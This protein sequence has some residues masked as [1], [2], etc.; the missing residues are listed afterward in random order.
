MSLAHTALVVLAVCPPSFCAAGFQVHPG[1]ISFAAALAQEPVN[2][3][4][5]YEKRRKEAE[6]D[7]KKLWSLYEWCDKN[8][9][10]TEARSCLRAILK[11][12]D[13]DKR[14]HELLGEVFYDG[15]WFPNEKKVEEYKQK[16]L[17]AKA[18]SS[19]KVIYKGEL[20]DPADVPF[21]EKGLTKTEDGRWVNAEEEKKIKE[22]WVRQDLEWIPP[23]EVPQKEKG[24]WKC[25][26]NWLAT[27]EAD[28]F[29]SEVGRWWRIPS[30]HF[31]LYSTCSRAVSEQALLKMESAYR[32]LAR[33][34]G[35]NP[36]TQVVVGL[37]NSRDQYGLFARGE[38][39]IP[40][41]E[42]RGLSSVHGSFMG[43]SWLEPVDAGFPMAGVAYWDV[44]NAKDKAFGEMFARHAAGQ[45]FAEALD[46]SPKTLAK[47]QKSQL[48]A[49]LGVEFWA[50]KKIPEWF[51]FGAA[52][53]VE[54]YM[55]DNL[56]EAGG[57]PQWRFKWSVENLTNKGGLDPLD[58][59]FEFKVSVDDIDGSNKL[60][61]ESGLLVAFV[62]DGKCPSVI[63]K[64]GALKEAIKSGKDI[65]KAGKALAEEL[66]KNEPKLR[67]FAN[68]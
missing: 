55:L 24:L 36:T 39:G 28:K 3:K 64:H 51:R 26:E 17:E 44:S 22:G 46:P 1:E 53:Y 31:V 54:R 12:D 8:D 57:D 35:R 16:E 63:E 32:E 29:H 5:E 61:N 27:A 21:L 40:Q 30:D 19:G 60:I 58:R 33:V 15:K 49:A 25:G 23:A 56:V 6:G 11:L 68:L 20:V 9:M 41:P 38:A 37:L 59:I 52:A 4:A 48:S 62:L 34:Y 50:E 42:A 13:R 2:K 65:E 10:K 7:E 45:S 43:E 14:A 47:I 18:K 67:A 66:K